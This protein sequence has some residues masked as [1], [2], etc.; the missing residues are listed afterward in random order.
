MRFLWPFGGSLLTADFQPNLSS[1]ESLA[2]LRFRQALASYMPPEVV[3][4][5]HEETVKALASGRVAMITEWNGWHKWLADPATSRVADCLGVALEPAG[6]AGRKPAL[7]GFSL[8]V[9]ARSSPERKAA[10]WLFVQWLTSKAKAADYIRNGG[11]PGRRSAYR[12]EGLKRQYPHFEPLALSWERYGNAH[13]RP[14]FAEWHAISRVISDTGTKMMRGQVDVDEGARVID[15]Q[16]RYILF[17]S[18]YYKD[19]P[20]LQ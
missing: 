10:A 4:W 20:R 1:R 13:Y 2:G 15:A 7:G 12:D 14:R 5:D 9:G 6:P 18:G 8:G 11:F 17:E 19:K 16:I 3:E